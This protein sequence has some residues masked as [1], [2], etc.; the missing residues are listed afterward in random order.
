MVYSNEI[1]FIADTKSFSFYIDEHESTYLL[2]KIS[3]V[4]ITQSLHS[5]NANCDLM[6]I[7]K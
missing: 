5:L 3:V 7:Y 6:I 1:S 2:A 4:Y